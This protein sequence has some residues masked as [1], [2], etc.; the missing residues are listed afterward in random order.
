MSMP[1]DS[2]SVEPVPATLLH[3]DELA[4]Q[5]YLDYEQGGVDVQDASLGLD[6]QTW[7]LDAQGSQLVLR[8]LTTGAA[9][10]LLDTGVEDMQ[11]V[12]LAFNQNMDWQVAWEDGNAVKMRWLDT[13]TEQYETWT[14]SGAYGPGL[15]LD[16][17]RDELRSESDVLF[18]Y[19]RQGALYHRRQR[20][21]YQVEYPLGAVDP[22][23]VTVGRVGMQVNQ[24]LRVEIIRNVC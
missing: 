3:N 18:F 6:Y 2:L 11:H 10:L 22:T 12:A 7:R 8:A 20:D 5:R 24:R 15:A 19:L 16:D 13:L 14:E 17:R 23:S 9:Y 4:W 21:R 1:G